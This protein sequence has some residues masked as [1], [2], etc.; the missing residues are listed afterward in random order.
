MAHLYSNENFPFDMVIILRQLGHD[1][2][3]AYDAE[4]ANKGIPDA[5]V[6]EFARNQNRIVITLNRDDFLNLHHSGGNHAGII[7][8]TQTYL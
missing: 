1:V 3:T 4:Q 2:L 7:I 5:K 8:C 6:L